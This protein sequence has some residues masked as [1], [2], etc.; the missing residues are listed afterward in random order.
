MTVRPGPA[1]LDDVFVLVRQISIVR[2]QTLALELST[3]AKLLSICAPHKVR[4]GEE[5]VVLFFR[6]TS[7]LALGV[8]G[9]VEE[10]LPAPLPVAGACFVDGFGLPFAVFAHAI[11]E[12]VL[13]IQQD[14][15]CNG[16]QTSSKAKAGQREAGKAYPGQTPNPAY[17][18]W[19][20]D[21]K[22][23]SEDEW[24]QKS[25]TGK[26][27]ESAPI[28][29]A[30]KAPDGNWYLPDPNRKGKYLQVEVG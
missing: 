16:P 8:V 14:G 23:Y 5:A 7:L 17:P 30:R 24:K 11:L 27:S 25:A 13:W 28:N 26:R 1:T 12:R 9:E 20:G 18:I 3:K 29:G 2:R 10:E 6:K 22:W 4:P 19:G 15:I 21:G